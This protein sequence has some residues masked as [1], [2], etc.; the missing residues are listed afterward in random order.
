MSGGLNPRAFA[1]VPPPIIH[2]C[3]NHTGF[4]AE[5][6]H[7]IAKIAMLARYPVASW[8]RSGTVMPLADGRFGETP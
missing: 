4:V 5:N 3:G 1:G 6:P 2:I 8:L 7:R